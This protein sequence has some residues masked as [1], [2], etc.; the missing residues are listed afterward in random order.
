M[1]YGSDPFAMIDIPRP[2]KALTLE[3]EPKRSSPCSA[4]W[5]CELPSCF[6][7]LAAWMLLYM[8]PS[9]MILLSFLR[10]IC[11]ISQN[12]EVTLV[13]DRLLTF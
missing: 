3:L 1:A 4:P 6:E 10:T 9:Y 7:Y 11:K 5:T 2:C 12:P 13:G 8:A